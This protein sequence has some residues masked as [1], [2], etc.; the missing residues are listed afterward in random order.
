MTTLGKDGKGGIGQFFGQADALGRGNH[1][2]IIAGDDQHRQLKILETPGQVRLLAGQGEFPQGF[3]PIGRPQVFAIASQD[4]RR[5]FG[6]V[7][8]GD[9]GLGVIAGKEVAQQVGA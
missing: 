2:V 8:P 1:A 3:V 4:F 5:D 9:S 6:R 7:M